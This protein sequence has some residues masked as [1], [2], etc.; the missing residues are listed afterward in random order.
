[1]FRVWVRQGRCKETCWVPVWKAGQRKMPL[2]SL[3]LGAPAPAAAFAAAN[4]WA[5]S[6]V[7]GG[8]PGPQLADTSQLPKGRGQRTAKKHRGQGVTQAGRAGPNHAGYSTGTIPQPHLLLVVGGR[9]SY[10]PTPVLW[11]GKPRLRARCLARNDTRWQ[12][13]LALN[14]VVSC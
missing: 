10:P 5:E 4:G 8:G 9:C 11:R 3:V 2:E 14:C 12:G 6:H 1:M 7:L 13:H